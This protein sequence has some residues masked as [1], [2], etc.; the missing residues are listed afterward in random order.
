MKHLLSVATSLLLM[1]SHYSVAAEYMTL[2][3]TK[4]PRAT[5]IIDSLPPPKDVEIRKIQTADEWR[6]PFV[7]VYSD[8]YELILHDQERSNARLTLNELENLL[9]D[10]P[11]KRWPLG[12]VIAVQRVGPLSRGAGSKIASNLRV[13]K[14]ML[15]SHKLRVDQWPGA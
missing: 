12:K 1:L 9:L 5:G 2:G 3:Q 4:S 6:N 13:L 10:Q 7:I 14:R 8:G 11:S 15:E